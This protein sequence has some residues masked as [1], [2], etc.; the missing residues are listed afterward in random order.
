[1]RRTRGRRLL[2]RAVTPPPRPTWQ[3]PSWRGTTRISFGTHVSGQ[4][5]APCKER[6]VLR[7]VRRRHV[8][9]LVASW[10]RSRGASRAGKGRAIRGTGN[11]FLVS[12]TSTGGRITPPTG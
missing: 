1:M 10:Q 9:G 6:E 2:G 4:N 12:D 11:R 5:K 3:N 8:R 7:E